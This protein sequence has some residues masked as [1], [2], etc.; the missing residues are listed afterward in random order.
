MTPQPL[1]PPLSG[2]RVLDLTRL[3]PGPLA[4]QHLAAMGADVVKVEDLGAGDYA[5]PSVRRLVN[6]GKR[7]LRL[8]LKHPEGRALLLRLAATADV[9]MEGFRP[10]VLARLGVGP[11]VLL[12]TH[13]RLVVCSLSGWGQDGPLRDEPGHDLNYAALAGVVDQTAGLTNLPM[14]DLLG[15]TMHAVAAI[16]AALFDAARSG[17]GRHLDIAIADGVLA[18][19]VLPLATLN[20]TGRVTPLGEG[21]LTGA[22]ACYGL[23]ATA[24]GR[25]LAV[26]ALEHRFWE[27][28]CQRLHRPDLIPLHRN[29]D[30]A[31]EA[32]VRDELARIFGAQPLAHWV[33]AFDG[34]PAC[35]TPVLR[36]DETLAHP[37][38][39]ARGM[40]QRDALGLQQLG[41]ALRTAGE[42]QPD[43]RQAPAPGEHTDALLAELGLDAPTIAALRAAGA[44]G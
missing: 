42:P 36:L 40:A 13:P 1:P 30:P 9:L 18:H 31:T 12:Q 19:A 26:G 7:G 4:A 43:L 6:R 14:A 25:Q 38:F 44:V 41:T 2:V 29:A 5:S 21:T 24:D 33:A 39:Q 35:V 27:A 10:G 8:D 23:Y 34:V 3:L 15:G 28:L 37:H 32:R 20:A 22:L 17:R 11:D 16:T